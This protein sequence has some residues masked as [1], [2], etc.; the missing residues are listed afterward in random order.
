[1]SHTQGVG[2]QNPGEGNCKFSITTTAH[3]ESQDGETLT[4]IG[5]DG[6][7]ALS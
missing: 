6:L 2:R 7:I 5:F 3:T 4:V 1:M